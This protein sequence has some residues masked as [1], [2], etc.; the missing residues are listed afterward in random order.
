MQW[1]ADM[2][3]RRKLLAAFGIVLV[4]VAAE[5]AFAY[6]TTASSQEASGWVDH[7]SQVI[8]TADDALANLVNM[9]T[10]YRGFLVIGQDAFPDPYT[11][12]RPCI[13]R[14]SRNFTN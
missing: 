2:P 4:V 6:K 12:A 13:K 7:T 8:S 14:T 1:I 10:G 3:L 9:E 11:A 5:S